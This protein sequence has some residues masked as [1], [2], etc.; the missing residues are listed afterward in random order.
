M[1]TSEDCLV[2]MTAMVLGAISLQR[3]FLAFQLT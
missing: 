2:L 3:S 1:V